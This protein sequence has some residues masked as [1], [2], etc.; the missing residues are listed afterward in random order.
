MSCASDSS[1]LWIAADHDVFYSDA[2][3]AAGAYLNSGTCTWELLDSASASV[4]TGTLSYVAASDGDY[5][6][7]IPSTVTDDLTEDSL[8]YL[9]IT[10]QDGAYDDFRRLQLRAAY[11]RLT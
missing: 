11:R 7:T 3:N 8:Y 1:T 10:F 4:A 9:E 2:R 5:E 6:G